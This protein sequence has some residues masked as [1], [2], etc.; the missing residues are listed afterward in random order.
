M[1]IKGLS[2]PTRIS[3]SSP[4]PMDRVTNIHHSLCRCLFYV[5]AE[6]SAG[7]WVQVDGVAPDKPLDSAVLSRSKQFSAMSKL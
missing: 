3:T 4:K 6:E 2:T 5:P 1:V 7:P